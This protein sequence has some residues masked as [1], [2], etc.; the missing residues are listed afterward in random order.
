MTRGAIAL[1]SSLDM[2]CDRSC[3]YTIIQIY[4]KYQFWMEIDED[5]QIMV[6]EPFRNS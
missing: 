5:L 3:H 2:G 6:G 4:Y 1:A